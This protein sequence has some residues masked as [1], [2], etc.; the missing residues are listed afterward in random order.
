MAAAKP[1]QLDWSIIPGTKREQIQ[2]AKSTRRPIK[3]E[4]RGR[5]DYAILVFGIYI[6]SVK[7]KDAA[8]HAA[9]MIGRYKLDLGDFVHAYTEGY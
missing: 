3:I 6:G 9:H 1:A 4:H 8:Q 7:S 2:L 5:G